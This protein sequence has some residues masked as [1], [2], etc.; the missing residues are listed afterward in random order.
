M[1]VCL[2]G[3]T[4]F[5]GS[6]VAKQLSDAGHS[7]TI[8]ARNP[9][10]VH[11]LAELPGVRIVRADMQEPAA[12][13]RELR[14][15]DA[16]VHIALCWGET[17]PRMILSE[18]LASVRLLELAIEKG[19]KQI[20]YTSSTACTGYSLRVTDETSPMKPEDFYGASKGAV[21][22]FISAY[23]RNHPEVRFNII[24]PGYTFGNPVV[25]G[26]SI[27]SDRRFKDI[28]ARATTHRTIELT[29]NDGTQFIWAGDLALL[30]R[31]VIESDA[32]GEVFFGLSKNFVTWEQIARWAIEYSNS[33]SRV[34]LHDRGYSDDPSIFDVAKIE[35]FFGLSFDP[36]EHLQEHIRYLLASGRV[37]LPPIET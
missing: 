3:G 13:A 35:K 1:N 18:T 32:A 19:A 15:P 9:D 2:T 25:E 37:T 21:E 5:I 4:G 23:A 26:A 24:R 11:A 22:L 31:K 10:K 36:R 34:V 12:L 14:A 6:Y 29:K 33:G 28:C 27:E 20:L 16:V 8:L 17:G 7:I 30:Y